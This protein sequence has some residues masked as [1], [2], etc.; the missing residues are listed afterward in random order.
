[1]EIANAG[2]WIVLIICLMGS[3]F[4]SASET[5][6]TSINKVR[7][8]N[9]VE[10]GVSG[11]K[12]V[13]NLINNPSKLLGTIL[14]G[15]NVVNIGASSLATSIAIDL[16]GST[17]V[18][19]AT[20]VMTLLVLIFGEITPKSLATEN[21]EKIAFKV[22]GFISLLATILSPIVKILLTITDGISRMLGAKS[23]DTTPFITKSELRTMLNVSH[24]EGVIESGEKNMIVNVFDFR[25]VKLSKIMTPRTDMSAMDSSLNYDQIVEFSKDYKYSRVPVYE[26][27]HD[28]I[29]G[30]FSLK[31]II[32]YSKEKENFD[33]NNYLRKPVYLYETQSAESAFE[34]MRKKQVSIAIVIDEYGGT[35]GLVTIEDIIEVIVGDIKD[36]YDDGVKII[37]KITDKEYLIKGIYQIDDF[38]ERFNLKLQSED[39]ETIGG[40]VIE[41]LGFIPL[42]KEELLRENYR[43]I[44]E[45]VEKNRVEKIRLIFE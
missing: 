43:I 39:Y 4:F 38:N 11:A 40:Y 21:S 17:G 3:A 13:E 41:N 28:D 18:G 19:I 23:G 45:E 27:N 6:L 16:F 12:T 35:S 32:G 22:A 36:E 5:A 29:I 30:I 44:V 14:V 9:M 42:G 7:V 26:E 33:I 15:N 24:E 10:D 1:M 8:R 25:D 31:D 2:R 37:Q 20:G 34:E